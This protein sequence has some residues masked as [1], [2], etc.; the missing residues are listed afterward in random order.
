M[1]LPYFHIFFV[2]PKVNNCSFTL[3]FSY[4][5]ICLEL[6]YF[7]CSISYTNIAILFPHIPKYQTISH[8]LLCSM[9]TTSFRTRLL[10]GL[11]CWTTR[12]KGRVLFLKP[13]PPLQF[14]WSSILPHSIFRLFLFLPETS[15]SVNSNK[16]YIGEKYLYFLSL[17]LLF[18]FTFP[19]YLDFF[20]LL[21]LRWKILIIQKS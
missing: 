17:S 7:N 16:R 8:I 4:F 11:D 1:F 9:E 13:P 6:F 3:L 10:H 12:P 15:L 19:P 2:F 5:S 21:F 18:S 20:I 14:T